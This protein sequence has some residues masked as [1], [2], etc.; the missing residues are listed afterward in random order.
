VDSAKRKLIQQGQEDRHITI[1]LQ[2]SDML[3]QH[4]CIFCKRGLFR[5]QY[6]AVLIEHGVGGS[7]EEMVTKPISLQCPT[8]ATFYHLQILTNK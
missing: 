4:N 5:S 6:R 7:H 2:Y 1:R 8:C 3:L